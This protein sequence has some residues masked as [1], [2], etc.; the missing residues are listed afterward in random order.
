M[1]DDLKIEATDEPG[2]FTFDA[3]T[4]G[5]GRVAVHYRL[6]N[7]LAASVA[8]AWDAHDTEVLK[9]LAAEYEEKVREKVAGRGQNFEPSTPSFEAE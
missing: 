6:P 8:W 7:G 4:F 9:R 5:D 3:I 2:E 1:G